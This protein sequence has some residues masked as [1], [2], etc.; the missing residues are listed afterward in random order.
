MT[1]LDELEVKQFLKELSETLR[2]KKETGLTMIEQFFYDR[3]K[4]LLEK[5]NSKTKTK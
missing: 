2:D 5:L 1:K 4:E 3:S